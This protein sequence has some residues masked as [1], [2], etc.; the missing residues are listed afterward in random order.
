M[1]T[2][3]RDSIFGGTGV[4]AAVVE[5]VGTTTGAVLTA[6]DTDTDGDGP[7][8]PLPV[9]LGGN[10]IVGFDSVGGTNGDTGTGGTDTGLTAMSPVGPR[11]AGMS[12]ALIG[13]PNT[14]GPGS[15]VTTGGGA[16]NGSPVA[17][18][19]AGVTMENV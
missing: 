6:P 15:P 8:G 1:K 12:A 10:A 2:H 19:L 14:T 11:F 5:R 4:S 16:G 7:S 13:S 9:G 3:F 17:K 18:S